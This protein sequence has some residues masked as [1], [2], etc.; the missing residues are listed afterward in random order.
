M[1]LPAVSDIKDLAAEFDR[2]SRERDPLHLTHI[3]AQH[4]E[5]PESFKWFV[6]GVLYERQRKETAE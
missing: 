5:R 6:A 2:L 4:R 1:P 3:I